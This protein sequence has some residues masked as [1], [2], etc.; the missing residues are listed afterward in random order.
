MRQG[1]VEAGLAL[2]DEAMVGVT[3]GE[4]SPLVAGILYCGVIHSCQQVYAMSRCREWTEGFARWCEQQPEAAFTGLCLVHRSEILQ[5]NGSWRDAI[6]EA[7]RASARLSREPDPAAAAEASYQ[8]AEVHRLRGEFAEAE[9]AYRRATQCGREPQ[10]GLALLRLA[11]G[12]T[13]AA[14]AQIRRV[15]GAATDRLQRVRLLPACVE[16]LLAAREV[17]EAEQACRE[18]AEPAGIFAPA[19]LGAMAA[20]ARGAVALARGDARAALGPLR[21]SLETWQRV[22]APYL[23]A[24]LRMLVSQACRALGDD[25]G[26]D[27]ELDAARAV[28]QDL[29]AAPDLA[30]LDTLG[31]RV[32]APPGLSPRELQVLRRVAAG[33]TN[34]AIAAELHLSERTVDRHVSNIFVKLGVPSRAAA[35]AFA[36]EHKLV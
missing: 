2:L 36:Y 23:A 12:R 8:E 35:T 14:A 24:R 5:F 6:D 16:I 27:L 33:R 25:E 21:R 4:V 13:D 22:G 15:A 26:A 28:L 18:L 1:R 10:P 3:T 11:E 32:P 19:V 29:G 34:K 7:R 17:E 31:E 9:E 30:R 20:H